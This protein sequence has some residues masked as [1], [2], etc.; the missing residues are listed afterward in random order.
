MRVTTTEDAPW[1]PTDVEKCLATAVRSLRQERGWT[2]EQLAARLAVYGFVMH[3]TTIAKLEA[4]ERPIRLNEAAALA[5]IFETTLLTLTGG[6]QPLGGDLAE[7]K[8]RL[9]NAEAKYASYRA[10]LLDAARDAGEARGRAEALDAVVEKMQARIAQVGRE[11]AEARVAFEDAV[12]QQ[13]DRG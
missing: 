1:Q 6:P 10:D 4:A 13:A 9:D 5:A 3:Q 2:Q 8:Q 11:V 7:A 12:Q